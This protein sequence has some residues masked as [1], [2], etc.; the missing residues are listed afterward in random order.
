MYVAYLLRD[1]TKDCV[2]LTHR[3]L[4]LSFLNHESVWMVPG[5]ISAD[6]D[7]LCCRPATDTAPLAPS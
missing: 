1:D 5:T 7:V 6:D 2:I 4:W 3:P